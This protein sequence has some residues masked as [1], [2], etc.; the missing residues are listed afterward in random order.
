MG[1]GAKEMLFE[2]YLTVHTCSNKGFFLSYGHTSLDVNCLL[3]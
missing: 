3:I 1:L 2:L